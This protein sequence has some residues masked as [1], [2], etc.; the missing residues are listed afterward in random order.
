MEKLILKPEG[1]VIV[2]TDIHGCMDKLLEL[3][4]KVNFCSEDTLVIAGDLV[5]RGPDNEAVID[6]VRTRENV[7]SIKGNHEWLAIEALNSGNYYHTMLHVANG[8]DWLQTNDLPKQKEMVDF[9]ISLPDIIEIH[10]NG[11]K[12]GVIH[13]EPDTDD[14]DTIGTETPTSLTWGRERLRG[15]KPATFISNVEEIYCGHTI[16]DNPTYTGNVFHMDLGA[17]LGKDLC[18]VEIN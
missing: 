16:V 10:K 11:K 12:Y 5:D 8:G 4:E 18:Y 13:A 3:L 7:Y 6:F 15:T 9:L 1:R 17:F 2:T 14:W